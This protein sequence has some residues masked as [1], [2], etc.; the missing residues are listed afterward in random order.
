MSEPIQAW[1]EPSREPSGHAP[2][3]TPRAIRVVLVEDHATVRRGLKMILRSANDIAVVGEAGDGEEAERICAEVCPDLVLMDLRLPRQG[4]VETIRALQHLQ[5][6]PQV[7]V[8]TAFYD[9]RLIPEA[10]AAGA[11]GYVL[12]QVSTAELTAAIRA[13]GRRT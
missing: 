12:K 6:V 10:L 7:L 2:A 11:V 13:A 4:G 9:E 5:P 8:L 3:L 1:G